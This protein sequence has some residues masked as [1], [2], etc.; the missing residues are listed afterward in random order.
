MLT[1]KT[2]SRWSRNWWR[3]RSEGRVYI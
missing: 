3:K 2:C 1:W